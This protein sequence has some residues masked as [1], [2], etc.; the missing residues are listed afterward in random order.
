MENKNL[1][2]LHKE[3]QDYLKYSTDSYLKKA[4]VYEIY[5]HYEDDII[6]NIQEI[7]N[8]NFT[9][10]DIQ[11][12]ADRIVNSYYLNEELNDTIQDFTRDYIKE[13]K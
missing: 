1:E 4:M 2:K 12:I 6:C 3:V 13:N 11:E 10:K 5:Y 7:R 9:L 8:A